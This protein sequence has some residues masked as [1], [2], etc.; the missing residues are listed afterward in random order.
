MRIRKDMI[1]AVLTTFCLC[2]LMFAVI[3]I[4][5]GLP[6]DP[7][8]DIDDSGKIDM[9]DIGNVAARFM[10][11]GDSTKNVTVTNWPQDRPL[12]IK[13]GVEKIVVTDISQGLEFHATTTLY[14]YYD[15]EPKGSFIN[16]TEVY[17]N[18]VSEHGAAY[19]F[20]QHFIRL[21]DTSPIDYHTWVRLF[22]VSDTIQSFRGTASEYAYSEPFNFSYIHQG[23]N[24]VALDNNQ[25]GYGSLWVYNFELFIEYYYWG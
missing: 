6:Y 4:Q 8:S 14:F 2:A 9:K 1:F 13:K 18:I 19:P 11:S 22:L 25:T 21:P 5:S 15:F 17:Y 23:M 16:V 24:K 20:G 12:T 3:P 7:W 10:T